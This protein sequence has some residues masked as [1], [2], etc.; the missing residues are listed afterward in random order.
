VLTGGGVGVGID[1]VSVLLF[2][3][4][5]ITGTCCLSG[6][7]RG[8]GISGAGVVDIGA[9]WRVRPPDWWSGLGKRAGLSGRGLLTGG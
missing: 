9:G 3:G 5:L 8:L 1:P 2:W 4:S 6:S 7:E